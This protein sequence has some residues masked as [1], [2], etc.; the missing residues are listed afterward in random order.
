MRTQATITLIPALGVASS[1]TLM[2]AATIIPD[3]RQ[4]TIVFLGYGR[5]GMRLDNG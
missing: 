4:K 3:I 5:I 2:F 1:G